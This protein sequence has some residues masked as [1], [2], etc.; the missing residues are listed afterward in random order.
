M[1]VKRGKLGFTMVEI[2]TVVGIIA[3]LVAVLIK[4]SFF[5]LSRNALFA[6]RPFMDFET[7]MQILGITLKTG[8]SPRLRVKKPHFTPARIVMSRWKFRVLKMSRISFEFWGF[9]ARSKVSNFSPQVFISSGRIDLTLYLSEI[10]F[11][12]K[13]SL[14]LT[15]ISDGS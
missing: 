10:N 14:S 8:I 13:G 6:K 2:L 7:F 9:T 11:I 1:A 3:I 5:E 15:S 4:E 12:F